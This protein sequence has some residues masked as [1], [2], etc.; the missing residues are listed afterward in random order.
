[1]GDKYMSFVDASLRVAMGFF[2]DPFRVRNSESH[3]R[4]IVRLPDLVVLT[5]KHDEM[6]ACAP[7]SR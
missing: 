7:S 1:M 2:L 4:C 3:S 6:K 5:R